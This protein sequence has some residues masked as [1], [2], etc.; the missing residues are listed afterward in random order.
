MQG[1]PHDRMER[2]RRM[3]R[4]VDGP[5][6]CALLEDGDNAVSGLKIA[7]GDECESDARWFGR[8]GGESPGASEIDKRSE[9][10]SFVMH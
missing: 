1:S 9:S 10:F 5:E 4:R 6:R 3:G 7:L 8:V 2:V